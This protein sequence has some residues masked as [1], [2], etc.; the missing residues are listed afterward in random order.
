MSNLL[1]LLA[2]SL[3][4]HRLVRDEVTHVFR[5]LAQ[6]CGVNDQKKRKTFEELYGS[7]IRYCIR[8]FVHFSIYFSLV[9]HLLLFFS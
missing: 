7:L 6:C 3:S 1:S 9:I 4:P 8:N 2:A 5:Y